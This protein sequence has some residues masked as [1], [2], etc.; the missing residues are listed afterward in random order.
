MSVSA[1]L[2]FFIYLLAVEVSLPRA[3]YKLEPLLIT[4]TNVHWQVSKTAHTLCIVVW[5]CAHYGL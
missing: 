3:P 4:L 5:H 2:H 1:E